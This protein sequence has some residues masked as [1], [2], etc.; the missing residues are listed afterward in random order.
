VGYRCLMVIWLACDLTNDD[1][2]RALSTDD[3][4]LQTAEFI[5]QLPLF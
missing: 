5:P 2:D 3:A 1:K 4:P